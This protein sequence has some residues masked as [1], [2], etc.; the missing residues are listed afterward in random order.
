MQMQVK[1]AD[2][3]SRLEKKVKP[4]T[5]KKDKL[6]AVQRERQKKVKAMQLRAAKEALA[7]L[8]AYIEAGGMLGASGIDVDR[9]Q[10]EAF[11]GKRFKAGINIPVS[12][13]L[14]DINPESEPWQ[15]TQI[16]RNEKLYL[17]AIATLKL[18]TTE[19]IT[20]D[21]SDRNG[22]AFLGLLDMNVDF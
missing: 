11:K 4:I 12:F 21:S 1:V 6:N 18:A 16:R 3:I 22:P 8:Q 19:E 2:L 20:L 15:L 14:E 9:P 13:K 7:R 5:A 10:R 17:D